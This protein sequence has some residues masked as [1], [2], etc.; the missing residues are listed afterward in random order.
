[1]G[2]Q[3]LGMLWSRRIE[4]LN[5]LLNGS[6]TCPSF[7]FYDP[8]SFPSRQGFCAVVFHGIAWRGHQA[9]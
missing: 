3:T 2:Y 5:E 1:M 6:I 8:V 9:I 7:Y 4:L